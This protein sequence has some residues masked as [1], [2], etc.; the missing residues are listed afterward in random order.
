MTQHMDRFA[1]MQQGGPR[2]RVQKKQPKR[3]GLTVRGRMGLMERE[4][5]PATKHNFHKATRKRWLY[6]CFSYPSMSKREV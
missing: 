3:T 4:K 2:K 5:K 6:S 1:C